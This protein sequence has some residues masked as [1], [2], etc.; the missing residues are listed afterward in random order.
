MINTAL[1]IVVIVYLFVVFVELL[2]IMSKLDDIKKV[3]KKK[4]D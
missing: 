3:L 1:L 2:I 4:E